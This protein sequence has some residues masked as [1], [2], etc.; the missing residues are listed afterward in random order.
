[1]AEN[2]YFVDFNNMSRSSWSRNV[3]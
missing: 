3:Y 2:F 1:M